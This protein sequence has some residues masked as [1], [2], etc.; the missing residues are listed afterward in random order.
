VTNRQKLTAAFGFFVLLV[1]VVGYAS[2]TQPQAQAS[3][4][5]CDSCGE[6]ALIKAYMSIERSS[7]GIAEYKERIQEMN[8]ELIAQQ[9]DNVAAT[10]TF[11][12]PLT[13]EGV[14]ELLQTYGVRLEQLQAR[15]VSGDRRMTIAFNAPVTEEMV[16]MIRQHISER[17]EA[18]FV[19][20]TDSYVVANYEAIG[21]L[22]KD[23]RVFLVDA[24][25][26]SYFTG[27]NDDQH[28]HALTW[29]LEYVRE[30]AK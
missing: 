9:V 15:A 27:E 11:D 25:G 21:E 22:Q 20:F 13:Y 26:D 17:Y 7:K 2:A 23:T 28:A 1:V 4:P 18:T 24:S 5:S 30:G 6:T 8:S 10:V 12:Q 3:T 19:G 29:L 14:Q 16:A